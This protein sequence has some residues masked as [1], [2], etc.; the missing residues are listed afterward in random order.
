MWDKRTWK[1]KTVE[2]G[3]QM[4]TCKLTGLNQDIDWFLTVVHASCDRNER[5]ELWEELGAMRSF[6][7]GPWVVCGDFNE[8]Q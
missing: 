2:Y 8:L 7:E 3:S 5:R 4:I 1:G 6:C